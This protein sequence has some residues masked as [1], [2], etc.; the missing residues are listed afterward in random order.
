MN[1]TLLHLSLISGIGPATVARLCEVVS[2]EKLDDLYLW[3]ASD[4]VAR[5][6]L[7]LAVA[8]ALVK[9]LRERT[10]LEQELEFIT[11]HEVRCC[12]LADEAYPELLKQIHYPPIVLYWWGIDLSQF[13]S[14]VA[15]VGSRAAQGYARQVID[16]LVPDLVQAGWSVVSGGALGA[17]TFAHTATLDAGGKTAAVIG[18]GLL[19]PYP[20]SNKRLFM[21]MREMGGAVI[22]PFP[23]TMQAMPGN[24]PA[25]NRIIAGLCKATVVVQAAEK[26]GA[27]ITALFALEQGREVGA[28]PGAITDPLS[29]GCHMLLRDGAF[30]VSSARD[31]LRACGEGEELSAKR[32]EKEGDAQGALVF[33]DELERICAD[34]QSFDD[35]LEQLGCSFQELQERLFN[36]QLQGRLTQDFMGRWQRR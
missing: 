12:T 28:V 32:I 24:F 20:A 19:Y 25:R 35:L 34:P 10:L 36:L 9:G 1:R 11:K 22:S 8:E 13:S 17:D 14:S 18:S 29:S 31:I 15:L 21:R 33:G 23:L 6:H 2:A 27:L 26:S 30:L 7:S 5:A 16:V 4:F 3:S